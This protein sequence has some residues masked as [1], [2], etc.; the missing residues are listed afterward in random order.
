MTSPRLP[1]EPS[2]RERKKNETRVR[3]VETAGRLFRELGYVETSVDRIAREAGVSLP[4]LFRYFPTKADLLFH[5]ADDVVTE[6]E[7]EM[8]AGPP[9]E[10]LGDALRRATHAIAFRTPAR[11][12]VARLRAELSPHD[13]ELRRKALEIDARLVGRIAT[14]MGEL[15]GLAPAEDVRPF[16]VAS[17]AMA[18]VRSAQ[19]TLGHSRR[20]KSDFAARIDEAFDALEGLGRTLRAPMKR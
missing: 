20:P 7:R 19:F 1:A 9:G 8:R 15:L 5:G 12:S 10:P 2:L 3:L 13:P 6:W 14:I 4:T 17:C 16:L 11:G 18:A